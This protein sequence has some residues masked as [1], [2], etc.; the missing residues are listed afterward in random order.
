MAVTESVRHTPQF[1]ALQ[2]VVAGRFSLEREIG[3]GEATVVYLARDVTLN[4]PVAIKLLNPDVAANQTIRRHF[5]REAR[6]AGLLSQPNIVPIHA[7]EEHGD[8]VF[9]VMGYVD[10]ESLRQWIT[11]TG[12]L[13][14]GEVTR[15]LREVAWA[16]GYAHARGIT[17]RDVKPDNIMIERDTGRAMVTDFGIARHVDDP[18]GGEIVGTASYMSPEQAA[19]HPVDARSDIYSL[20]V[21]AFYAIT[22]QLPFRGA[23]DEYVLLLHE[24]QPAPSVIG[25]RGGVPGRLAEI[26]DRC[27][28]KDPADR[29]TTA[30]E[31][32]SALGDIAGAIRRVPAVVDNFLRTAQTTS[33]RLM[34][35][36]PLGGVLAYAIGALHGFGIGHVLLFLFAS[37]ILVFELVVPAAVLLAAARNV[38]AQAISYDE[39]CEIVKVQAA[40]GSET[41]SASGRRFEAV[42]F[43]MA[44][45]LGA[46]GLALAVTTLVIALLRSMPEAWRLGL[47]SLGVSGIILALGALGW[48]VF[49]LMGSR[50]SRSRRHGVWLGPY[51]R[52]FFRLAAIG[53]K[54]ISV[55][56]RPSIRRPEALLSQAVRSA[57]ADL[58]GL[59]QREETLAV[60]GELEVKIGALRAERDAVDLV[61]DRGDVA[62]TP[63]G[64]PQ[65]ARQRPTGETLI[66]V[67]ETRLA[68][69]RQIEEAIAALESIRVDLLRIRSGFGSH[70]DLKSDLTVARQ[71]AAPGPARA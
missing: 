38:L 21:T 45:L 18:H 10:G 71:R 9:F 69:N 63:P 56:E 52:R 1:I 15:I 11:R 61:L 26:I 19:G 70:D 59:A 42:S 17:H 47:V 14:I 48:A 58:G 44:L 55:A 33:R 64:S 3:R 32:A 22:G 68:L 7:V 41:S 30:E 6:T 60:I 51:G 40:E 49:S 53:L 13:E 25:L 5:L 8:I 57:L 65:V 20:G 43:T 2:T 16:L 35:L 4:R 37:W 54:R 29:F 39:F 27:L 12:M 46:G 66:G 31:F 50:V 28:A 24:T 67:R 23:T 62:V 34:V 36:A